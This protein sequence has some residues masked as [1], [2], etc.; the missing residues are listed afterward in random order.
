MSL[1]RESALGYAALGWPVFPCQGKEPL[2]KHGF[3]DAT[4]DPT[5]ITTLFAQPCNL[6]IRTGNGICVLD[7]DVRAGKEGAE[8]LSQW[9]HQH[10]PLPKTRSVKTWSGGQ[11][12]YFKHFGP[13]RSKTD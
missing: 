4:T 7:I 9:E 2:T 5:L 11:H 10:E 3:K 13:L 12:Y 8:T 6:A 1:C